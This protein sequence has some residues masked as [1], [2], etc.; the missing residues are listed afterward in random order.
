MQEY[1]LRTMLR[2]AI[3]AGRYWLHHPIVSPLDRQRFDEA[4][5]HAEGAANN[6]NSAPAAL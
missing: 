3:A 1:L 5:R 6:Y 2:L 4:L